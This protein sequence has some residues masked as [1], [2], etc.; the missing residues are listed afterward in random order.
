MEFTE[1]DGLQN[2]HRSTDS[3][4]KTN[5]SPRA[6]GATVFYQGLIDPKGEEGM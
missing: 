5:H 4:R 3:V 1:S 2:V 6:T